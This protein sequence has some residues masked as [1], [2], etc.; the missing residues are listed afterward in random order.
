VDFELLDR[1][2]RERP[3]WSIVLIGQVGEGD[4]WMDARQ[5]RDRPNLHLLGPRPYAELPCYLKGFDVAL[6]P[7]ARNEYTDSMFPMKF[8]EYLAAGRPVVSVA[9]PALGAFRHAAALADSPESFIAAVEDALAGAAPPL[10]TRL[11]L[12]REHTWDARLDRML[13]LLEREPA[14]DGVAGTGL[15]AGRAA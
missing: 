14:R 4:P 15:T 2:A 10:E 7:S 9:L 1:I 13:A 5:L 3:E 8:F 11:A 12:A 6:L